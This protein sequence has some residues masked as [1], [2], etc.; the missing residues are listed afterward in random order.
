M[1][2][3]RSTSAQTVVSRRSRKDDA[4]DKNDKETDDE[5]IAS[6]KFYYCCDIPGRQVSLSHTFYQAILC[7]FTSHM[8]ATIRLAIMTYQEGRR[9]DIA[10]VLRVEPNLLMN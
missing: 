5:E 1:N 7:V 3:P 9:D 2:K 10:H 8:E 4:Q 6:V